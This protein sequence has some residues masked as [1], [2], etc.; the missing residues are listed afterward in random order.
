MVSSPSPPSPAT[1]GAESASAGSVSPS[2][3]P[4]TSPWVANMMTR[5]CDRSVVSTALL[6]RVAPRY[7]LGRI[8]LQRVAVAVTSAAVSGSRGR[9]ASSAL[10]TPSVCGLGAPLER[11]RASHVAAHRP[12]RRPAAASALAFVASSSLKHGSPKPMKGSRVGRARRQVPQRAQRR[13]RRHQRHRMRAGSQAR[14]DS[15]RTAG[16]AVAPPA[17]ARVGNRRQRQQAERAV[18]HDDQVLAGFQPALDRLEQQA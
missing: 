13:R 2:R 16:A 17:P 14:C 7:D 1:A 11:R 15:W 5:R 12:R 6:A 4:G 18:G 8:G 10:S 3:S 9:W